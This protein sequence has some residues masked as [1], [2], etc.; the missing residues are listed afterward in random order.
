[1]LYHAKNGNIPMGDTDMDYIAFGHGEKPLVMIPGV[2]DGLKTVRGMAIPFAL[3]YRQY[4]AAYR[5]YVFSRKNRLEPGYSTRDMAE[6]LAAAMEALGIS[7]AYVVGV[8]QGGMIAQYLA[9]EHPALV[10]KLVLA[11][12]LARPNETMQEAVGDWL[13]M[14]AMEDYKGL[15]IDMAERLY[16][17]R[18]LKRYRRLY[19]L[20]CRMSKPKEY[21]RFMIQA[22]ACRQHDAFDA[23]A[24]IACPTLVIGGGCDRIVGEEAAAELAGGIRGSK[25]LVYEGLGHGAYEEAKDFHKQIGDFF[26]TEA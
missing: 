15:F 13:R 25:L 16:S 5:V 26:D 14:A 6:D 7:G 11:V 24:Q 19:P 23:L 3:L 20:L 1:M 22:E 2:G 17:E 12:S 8:S 9:I 21:G 4:A 18:Y 10:D